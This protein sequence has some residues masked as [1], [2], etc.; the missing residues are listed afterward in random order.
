M[1]I[2]TEGIQ[3]DGPVEAVPL[4][5]M[6][7]L[8]IRGGTLR[9]VGS[10]EDEE[11][12]MHA[13]GEVYERVGVKSNHT[14]VGILLITKDDERSWRLVVFD[15]EE[16]GTLIPHGCAISEAL[17]GIYADTREEMLDLF[18]FKF[19]ALEA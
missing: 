15:R 3:Y 12:G 17:L 6:A 13:S 10:F 9:H 1:Q 8:G 18:A 2:E 19:E 4:A 5:I 14:H 11:D 7:L 16:D